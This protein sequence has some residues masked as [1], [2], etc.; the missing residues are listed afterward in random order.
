VPFF[1]LPHPAIQ[2][3]QSF[4]STVAVLGT[5]AYFVLVIAVWGGPYGLSPV[6]QVWLFV[7]AFFPIVMLLWSFT[8]VHILTSSAKESHIRTINEQIQIALDRQVKA[9]DASS[10]DYLDKV[11]NVQARVQ[12]VK[13]WPVWL[14]NVVP[15]LIGLLAVVA[16]ILV[17]VHQVLSK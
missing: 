13:E 11:M 5:I 12:S 17:A 9:G 4:C 15:I 14:Q 10:I 7:L 1:F 3:L 6:I 16:Q 2:S 8:Q